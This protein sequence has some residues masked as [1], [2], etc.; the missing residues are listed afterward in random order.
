MPIANEIAAKNKIDSEQWYGHDMTP[1]PMKP[2]E[3]HPVQSPKVKA[4]DP[5][6]K[7]NFKKVAGTDEPWY[8]FEDNQD[9]HT[10]HA[11]SRGTSAGS[12]ENKIKNKGIPHQ[13]IIQMYCFVCHMLTPLPFNPLQCD[14]L[15]H[16]LI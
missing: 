14:H 1:T 16:G 2:R 7:D 15:V 11:H 5:S 13:K 9:Y 4:S 12:E 10:P 6:A 3:P 8:K